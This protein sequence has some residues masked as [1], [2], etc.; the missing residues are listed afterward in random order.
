MGGN[1]RTLLLLAESNDAR[2][3]AYI[4]RDINKEGV[5][6]GARATTTERATIPFGTKMIKRRFGS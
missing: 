4:P 6:N 2:S 3:P 5:G 1:K